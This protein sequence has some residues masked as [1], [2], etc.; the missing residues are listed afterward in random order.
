MSRN[1]FRGFCV[2]SAQNYVACETCTEEHA[3][4][5]QRQAWSWRAWRAIEGAWLLEILAVNRNHSYMVSQN[6]REFPEY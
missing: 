5:R 3:G 4:K 2:Q 6:S 1:I